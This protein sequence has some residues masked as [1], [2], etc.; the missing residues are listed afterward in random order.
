M[1]SLKKLEESVIYNQ[2]SLKRLVRSITLSQGQFSLILVCCNYQYL[3]QTMIKQLKKL[4][5]VEIQELVLPKS[6]KTLYT[7]IDKQQEIF[8]EAQALMVFDLDKVVAIDELLTSTNQVRDEFRK[9]FSFPLVLWIKDE[10]LAKLIRLAP[11]FKSWAAATIKFELDT[12]ELID[13]LQVEIESY[14]IYGWENQ[15]QTIGYSN[16]NSTTHSCLPNSSTVQPVASWFEGLCRSK[17]QEIELAL[18]DLKNR[19]RELEPILKANVEFIL[20]RDDYCQEKID[21]AVIHY[22]ESLRLWQQE[23]RQ[24]CYLEQEYISASVI[25]SKFILEKQGIILYNIALCYHFKSLHH[26]LANCQK[27]KQAKLTL[28]KSKQIFEKVNRFDLVA[29]VISTLGQVIKQMKAWGELEALAKEGL[30]IHL[31]YGNERQVALDYGFL[32]EVA[33]Q[34]S[35][36]N[37][38]L[39]LSEKALHT[40]FYAK[41]ITLPTEKNSYILLLVKSLREIGRREEAIEYLEIAEATEKNVIQNGFKTQASRDPKRYLDIVTELRSLYYEKGKYLQAFRLKKAQRQ[42]AH[43]YGLLAFIGASQL[44]PKKQTCIKESLDYQNSLPEEITASSRQKDISKLVER[45]SR[46]DYKLTI[47]HGRSGVGKSS[48]VN[49]GLVP[50]LNNISISARDTVPVVVQVYTDWLGELEKCLQAALSSKGKYQQYQNLQI[51]EKDRQ[52]QIKNFLPYCNANE[53]NLVAEKITPYFR[54]ITNNFKD[55]ECSIISQLKYNADRNLL[56]VIIFDQ[57]EEFFF[58]SNTSEEKEAFYTFLR[59]CLNIPFV[60]VILSMREDYLHYLLECDFIN[61]LDVINN[62]ILD[63]QIRYHITDFSREDAYTIIECLTKKSKFNLEPKLIDVIVDGLA[64]EKHKIRPI[65]LQVVGS[66]LQEEKPPI[67]TLAQFEKKFGTNPQKAKEKIVREFLE[68]VIKDCGKE[69]EETTMQILFALT[70]D[71][72]TRHSRTKQELSE[73]ILDCTIENL[74]TK[75]KLEQATIAKL[76]LANQVNRQSENLL[77]IILEI[78]IDSGILFV[79]KEPLQKQY[80]LVHDYLVKPIRQR[81]NLEERLRQAEAE[82]QQAEIAKKQAQAEKIISESQLNIVLR[83]QLAAAIIGIIFM[84][85]STIATLGFWQRT[86]FQKQ[87]AN[88]QRHR[89]DINSMTAVSEALFFSD[90]RFDALIESLR[91]GKKWKKIKQS[92]AETYLSN[93]TEYRIAASLQQAVYG[94]K[95]Y[96]HLEGHG[97][98]IWSVAFHPQGNL[99]ASASVDKTIKLWSRN[100]KLQKTLKGHTESVSRI[101][102]SPD[103]KNLASASHDRTIKIWH[104]ES[105][106]IKPISLKGHSDWVT[107][108]NFSPNSKI[109]A[110]GSLDKTIKIWSKTGTLLKTIKTKA[111][112]NWVSFSPDGRLIAAATAN[113]IVQLWNLNGRLLTTLKHGESNNNYA[114]YSV[115]FSPDGRSL[116]TA[117]E[118]KTVKIWHL[119]GNGSANI[120]ILQT[121]IAGHKKLVLSASFSPDGQIIASSSADNTIKIWSRDGT[122]LKTFYGHG[123]K[124]T[125]V[126]FSPDGQTLA[127]GSYDKTIKLWSL[128]T[129]SLDILQGHQHRVLGVSF[130]PDGETLASASQDN[131]IKLWSRTGK[132]LKTFR[133]HA[134]RV[135]SVSFS[136]DGQMLASGSYDNTVKLWYFNSPEKIGNLE[137]LNSPKHWRQALHNSQDDRYSDSTSGRKISYMVSQTK[138][139]ES[140]NNEQWKY[141]QFL[142]EKH[143]MAIFNRFCH[144]IDYKPY[145]SSN[146]QYPL[147]GA[148]ALKFS[149]NQLFSCLVKVGN[150]CLFPAHFSPLQQLNILSQNMSFEQRKDRILTNTLTANK[151]PCLS[152]DSGTVCSDVNWNSNTSYHPVSKNISL[153]GHT[154]SVMSVTFSPNGQIIASGSKDKT[155]KLWKRNGKLLKTLAGHQAWVNSVSF[156]PDGKMLASASDDGTVKLWSSK[157]V[158]LRTI[159]AHNN[160]V[161]GVSFSPDGQTIATAGYDNMVKLWNINGKLVK[162]FLKGASDSVTSVSFSPDGQIIASSSY[163]GKVKLWSLYDGNL[164]KTLIGHGDSVMS[165]SFSPDGK[166]LASG[167]RDKTVILWNLALDDL[168]V[169]A[170]NWVSDYLHTNPNVSDSDRHLCDN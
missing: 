147:L 166:L 57:F 68:Q 134:D 116:V 129:S 76:N 142:E 112:I 52:Q 62:N 19:D 28:Q 126:S 44:Q 58:T 152:I 169:Q 4:S 157:G 24:L 146:Y 119:P 145:T 130:S 122:L 144:Q 154:D 107:T 103:G 42:I 96:N 111:A 109:L 125:Q 63:K 139:T 100:G 26:P 131:T 39:K 83:R 51:N 36:W 48:L 34:N 141:C 25:D 66:Q 32:A 5:S 20:G 93:D 18:N 82:I 120:P 10:L 69:N 138:F 79:R 43:Q 80:Q 49:A 128:K 110:S 163:D 59:D 170:C 94:V 140:E 31:R 64:D 87:V 158:L 84:S 75:D 89:A 161:L 1:K 8:A 15:E 104:L 13:L 29:Q 124:I 105:E 151:L 70:N 167:S 98:V 102:F 136:P 123:D 14:L 16:L 9:N 56:T 11:D 90:Y 73:I 40:L 55:V 117:S 114:V 160:W 91:A 159:N 3:Q 86:I 17:R 88:T 164:L 22:Q 50:A 115:N 54:G 65:E 38:A 127:S 37:L 133:G 74:P 106:K 165:V 135:A 78:L 35:N 21:H 23:V 27:L 99:I 148:F 12:E 77:D 150:F 121:T 60:K 95:E 153:I 7:T 81:F 33:L 168:L 71:N 156:S 162:T 155:V 101:S 53:S 108:V 143:L 61:Y 85:G 149:A 45:I 92:L 30:E 47:I 67:T 118:D 137:F 113:G 6:V 132:F 2:R 72:L 97:D 41:D 46:D